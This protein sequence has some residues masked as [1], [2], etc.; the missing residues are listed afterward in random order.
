[1][2]ARLTI[3]GIEKRPV[4]DVVVLVLGSGFREYG[5]R[6]LTATD[7]LSERM[8][9]RCQ[10]SRSLTFRT[11]HVGTPVPARHFPCSFV[12]LG[13][14]NYMNGSRRSEKRRE[15]TWSCHWLPAEDG[16]YCRRSPFFG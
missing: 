2:D 3:L 5:R 13:V 7:A 8:H 16:H 10:W 12:F 6:T 9:R 11:V 15:E 1:M 4:G 14:F